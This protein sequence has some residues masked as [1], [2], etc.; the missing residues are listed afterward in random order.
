M[1]LHVKKFQDAARSA[2]ENQMQTQHRQI[3]QSLPKELTELPTEP[4]YSASAQSGRFPVNTVN[5]FPNRAFV[6]R[7]DLIDR[8]FK[9]LTH[10][11]H[12]GQ[13]SH[14]TGMINLPYIEKTADGPSEEVAARKDGDRAPD[15]S[16]NNDQSN[17]SDQP[18]NDLVT[19]TAN[20]HKESKQPSDRLV[21]AT[22]VL[23]G[24]GGVGKTQIALEYY[25][26]YRDDYDAAF[27]VESEHDWTLAESYARIA[28]KLGLLPKKTSDAGGD[29]IQN[30]AIEAA[31]SWLQ[32]TSECSSDNYWK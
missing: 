9:I 18:E 5:S 12:V 24:L 16:T 30:I 32:T 17:S 22:C 28:D 27:W 2:H 23:H 3:E 4:L 10:V 15:A 21:P 26:R 1:R 11:R 31:R 8:A 14:S 7:K 6:G 13:V 20:P 29:E 25:Y 19:S